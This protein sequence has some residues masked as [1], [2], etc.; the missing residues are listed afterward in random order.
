MKNLNLKLF[1]L[2]AIC[3]VAM[4]VLLGYFGIKDVKP[5]PVWGKVTL[6]T[7]GVGMTLSLVVFFIRKVTGADKWDEITI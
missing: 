3:G 7:L 1:L 6:V 2:A 4:I 5:L